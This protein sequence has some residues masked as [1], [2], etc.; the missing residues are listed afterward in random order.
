MIWRFSL[1]HPTLNGGNW[2]EI[3]EPVGWDEA[4]I[5]IARD[6]KW[7][8]IDVT[9]SL[10]LKFIGAGATFLHELLT[11]EGIDEQVLCRVEHSTQPAKQL[12]MPLPVGGAGGGQPLY[13]SPG[14]GGEEG[15]YADPIQG[16]WATVFEGRVNLGSGRLLYEDGL[17][18][19]DVNIEQDGNWQ[20][21]RSRME[22]QVD[23]RSLSSLEST[24]LPAY[25]YAPY[26]LTL[27]PRGITLRSFVEYDG[28][29]PY[30][31]GTLLNAAPYNTGLRFDPI[32]N[33]ASTVQEFGEVQPLV[34][35]YFGF[36]GSWNTPAPPDLGS[37]AATPSPLLKLDAASVLKV[38]VKA[39]F[40]LQIKVYNYAPNFTLL[41]S[42]VFRSSPGNVV[43]GGSQYI[44]EGPVL[45]N[46]VGP[47]RTLTYTF[48][49]D[50]SLETPLIPALD[51]IYLYFEFQASRNI[52][53]GIVYF[54]FL[55]ID[56]EFTFIQHSYELDFRTET[57][58]DATEVK[59]V[60]INEAF[61]RLA[62]SIT[63]G[64]VT[65]R[66]LLFGRQTT[67][68]Q[69]LPSPDK[70]DGTAHNLAV[71]NGLLIRRINEQID[72]QGNT[73]PTPLNMSLADLMEAANAC[74]NIGWELED[75][76]GGLTLP[77][78]INGSAVQLLR[79][80]EKRYFYKKWPLAATLTAIREYELSPLEK[81]HYTR[82]EAGYEKADVEGL[83][84]LNEFNTR[85]E[86]QANIRNSESTYSIRCKFVGSGYLIE[87]IRRIDPL[88][89]ASADTQNDADRFFI[90]TA[91]TSGTHA[92]GQA[93]AP[94][95][96]S[97]RAENFGT[98]VPG[99]EGNLLD[100]ERSY[101]LRIAPQRNVQRHAGIL[102]AGTALNDLHQT[103]Y[104]GS[105]A[106]RY[107]LADG[108]MANL[109]GE[110]NPT[111]D[112][113]YTRTN[114]ALN[115]A[116]LPS[117]IADE[118]TCDYPLSWRQYLTLRQ[119]RYHPVLVQD[120]GHA[121]GYWYIRKVQYE[122][123]KGMAKWT[124]VRA[125]PDACLGVE[126]TLTIAQQDAPVLI[127]A[128][129]PGGV[130]V[131]FT[132]D[133][134]CCERP[135]LID[136]DPTFALPEGDF[137][138]TWPEAGQ[139]TGTLTVPLGWD[140]P[141]L[142]EYD[143]VDVYLPFTASACDIAHNK[144]LWVRLVPVPPA[145]TG[146][147]AQS[148]QGCGNLTFTANTPPMG[149]VVQW[150]L[151]NFATVA[152]TGSSY[153][154]SFDVPG[155]P[156]TVYVRLYN[157]TYNTAGPISTT[158]ATVTMP[159]A[160]TAPAPVPAAPDGVPFMLTG[161]TLAGFTLEW[162]VDNFATVHGTGTTF[163][164]T[165]V[166]G[167][168]PYTVSLRWKDA[169]G[170]VSAVS[171][172]TVTVFTFLNAIEIDGALNQLSTPQSA[173]LD[174]GTGDF[175]ISL[176]VKI[177]PPTGINQTRQ[178]LNKFNIIGPNIFGWQ[179]SFV[180][181]P[182]QTQ[183]IIR[184]QIS[185]GQTTTPPE[186]RVNSILAPNQWYHIVAVRIG[187]SAA[188]WLIYVNGVVPTLVRTGTLTNG[189]NVNVNYPTG[190]GYSPRL[191]AQQLDGRLDEVLLI[192]RAPTLAEVTDLYNI[193]FG[194]T[195]PASLLP[196]VR[197]RWPM[198]ALATAAYPTITMADV[199]GNGHTLTGLNFPG[200]PLLPH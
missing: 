38:R 87:K 50:E 64:R 32:Y 166:I 68:S 91:K 70:V 14:G 116:Y 77:A 4:E 53:G 81:E 28:A 26:D 121:N 42:L 83:N 174:F 130:D 175:A 69:P 17:C 164:Y 96:H 119:Y 22:T 176:W 51:D 122:P 172:T 16:S 6:A 10:P 88:E 131:D 97:E 101:N 9:Y 168:S 112:R 39:S 56:Q 1:Q 127:T 44:W 67:A 5:T 15:V 192:N 200:N 52:G 43:V 41:P 170:N 34:S 59:A 154:A 143:P 134:S 73:I 120:S 126:P 194:A 197:A 98:F 163:T 55:D 136:G 186:C 181:L 118:L 61:A 79:V 104:E 71:S 107:V 157:T 128:I 25:T 152:H 125:Y 159:A 94:L 110:D 103:Y 48:D 66:S 37:V 11:T 40:E 132:L 137:F 13:S 2:T 147:T 195:P 85:R 33:P 47:T 144:T 106:E 99:T 155:S 171:T 57:I 178:L 18:L 31:Y 74:Y 84:G 19:F 7:H 115:E 45:I 183:G 24:A 173:L 12:R 145:A 180:F 8:G 90:C 35:P 111:E 109:G 149:T 150:S 62:E 196:N 140:V 29:N 27:L 198:D 63:G 188:N 75:R 117:Y 100:G 21:V 135:I 113:R 138:P 146:F 86:W 187:N 114:F 151:N 20:T 123:A 199:S 160:P 193:G 189:G 36:N 156:H 182:L 76:P 72:G 65:A 23:L 165:Y 158:T 89:N 108:T 93:Y 49:I 60:L 162:S 54:S 169:C 3:P 80:E 184:F 153:T 142:P 30:N 58:A 190:V 46:S 82:I 148:R 179:L 185:D 129:G 141:A 102:F 191:N 133:Q 92:D 105:D 167:S 78:Q 124:L 161:P 95:T 177:D 139:T